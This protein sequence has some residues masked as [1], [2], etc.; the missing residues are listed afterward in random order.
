VHG[1]LDRRRLVSGRQQTPFAGSSHR[2]DASVTPGRGSRYDTRTLA[3]D[4][5]ALMDALSHKRFAV[6]GH[7]APPIARKGSLAGPRRR[8]EASDERRVHFAS[9]AKRLQALCRTRTGDPEH[10]SGAGHA[11]ADADASA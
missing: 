1:E 9:P 8:P 6:V 3:N 4:L 10:D 7:A 5:V 11:G 2:P